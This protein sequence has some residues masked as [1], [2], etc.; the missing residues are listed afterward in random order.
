MFVVCICAVLYRRRLGVL[1]KV[2]CVLAALHVVSAMKRTRRSVGG[3]IVLAAFVLLSITLHSAASTIS[4]WAVIL[5]GLFPNGS[6]TK[7]YI[8]QNFMVIVEWGFIIFSF[9]LSKFRLRSSS[10][11]AFRHTLLD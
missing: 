2:F 8:E 7:R 5:V 1:K 4:L 6:K 10:N 11:L 3:F 9:H